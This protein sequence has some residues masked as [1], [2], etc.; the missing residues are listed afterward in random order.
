MTAG[1]PAG[2]RPLGTALPVPG[3]RNGIPC[4]LAVRRAGPGDGDRIR[5]FIRGL[6]ADSLY[7][8]FRCI[9]D[10]RAVRALCAGDVHLAEDAGDGT[11]AGHVM[12]VPCSRSSGAAEIAV[13]VG[14][15]WRRRGLGSAL[16]AAAARQARESGAIVLAAWISAG[17]RH[18]VGML[19][20]LGTGLRL[21]DDGHGELYAEV[22]LAGPRPDDRGSPVPHSR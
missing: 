7:G 16:A 12:T 18:Q 22:S 11:I 8:R 14:P 15:Q 17:A 2:P 1:T 4:G 13:I 9:P 21:S 5:A 10:I 19:G 3:T 20:R 6:D